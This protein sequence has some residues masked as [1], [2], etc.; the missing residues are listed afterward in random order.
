MVYIQ[1]EKKI[2]RHTDQQFN[3]DSPS[4]R[5]VARDMYVNMYTNTS[6]SLVTFWR[7]EFVS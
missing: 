1:G 7:E 3:T 4:L 2:S 6:I 5:S